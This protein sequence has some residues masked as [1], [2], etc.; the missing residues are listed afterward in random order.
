MC[1][2][3]TPLRAT[4][5]YCWPPMCASFGRGRVDQ[6]EKLPCVPLRSGTHMPDSS[7]PFLNGLG[8][9][10]IGTRRIEDHTRASPR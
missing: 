3:T 5:W 8:G 9:K 6:N 4:T 7:V 1:V 10:V 2:F